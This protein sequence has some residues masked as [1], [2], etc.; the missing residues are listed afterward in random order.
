MAQWLLVCRVP[1]RPTRIRPWSTAC[2]TCP[3]GSPSSCST[4]SAAASTSPGR[5]SS[6]WLSRTRCLPC[7]RVSALSSNG[8]V[9]EHSFREV[10]IVP[11][12]FS[13]AGGHCEQVLVLCSVLTAF[14]CILP[15]PSSLSLCWDVSFRGEVVSLLSLLVKFSRTPGDSALSHHVCLFLSA[16]KSSYVTCFT[17]PRASFPCFNAVCW[18]TRL[19]MWKALPLHAATW[20]AN[21]YRA[22]LWTALG[23]CTIIICTIEGELSLTVVHF[24]AASIKN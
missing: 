22:L 17:Q 7:Q 20:L 24:L 9:Q 2:T 6:S 5:P 23:K 11:S 19:P 12:Y 4:R 13:C 1:R 18:V 16:W 21:S 8:S 10:L 14:P 3:A 15:Q